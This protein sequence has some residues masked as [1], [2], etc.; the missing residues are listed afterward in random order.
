MG[1]A[2]YKKLLY[3]II[4]MAG[5]IMIAAALA[6]KFFIVGNEF[7]FTLIIIGSVMTCL[8]LVINKIIEVDFENKTA[9]FSQEDVEQLKDEFVEEFRASIQEIAVVGSKH[10]DHKRAFEIALGILRKFADAEEVAVVDLRLISVALCYTWEFI[11]N[12]FVPIARQNK[13]IQYSWKIA[14]TDP[15]Y[16]SQFQFDSKQYDWKKQTS[17]IIS[18]IKNLEAKLHED[19]VTNVSFEVFPYKS[20]PQWHGLLIDRKYLLI[21]RSDWELT[22]ESGYPRLTVGSNT[23]RYYNYTKNYGQLRIDLFRHWFGF[24]AEFSKFFRND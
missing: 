8:P 11:E 4:S 17:D 3:L 7:N 22:T 9:K 6:D 13:N 24:Y 16:L 1:S 23:Y 2:P 18:R 5:L 21:G 10:M 12:D 19:G 20:I 15:E 14:I